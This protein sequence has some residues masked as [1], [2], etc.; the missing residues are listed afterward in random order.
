M[1]ALGRHSE[2]TVE[3]EA[4]DQVVLRPQPQQSSGFDR[5]D[6]VALETVM[7]WRYLP[8]KRDGVPEAMSFVIPLVFSLE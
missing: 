8:G 2:P 5:L 6:K 4:P 3:L 7:K 1:A